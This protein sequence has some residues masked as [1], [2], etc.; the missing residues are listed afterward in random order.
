VRQEWVGGW[1][2]ILLEVKWDGGW[3]GG[4]AERRL[5]RGTTFKM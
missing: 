1:G 3:N 4:F 2:S 5:G